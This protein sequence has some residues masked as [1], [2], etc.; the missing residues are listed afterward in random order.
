MPYGYKLKDSTRAIAFELGR[1]QSTIGRELRQNRGQR[2]YRHKQAQ[3]K[4]QQRHAEKPK[5]LKLIPALPLPA[6][7]PST[8]MFLRTNAPVARCAKIYAATRRNTVSVTVAAR[9]VSKASPPGGH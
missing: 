2:G 7:R 6:M 5:A 1:S 3:G 4:A 8:G 9:A